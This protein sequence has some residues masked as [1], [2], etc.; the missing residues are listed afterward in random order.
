M[1]SINKQFL[2]IH[3]PKTGGNSIQIALLKYSEDEKVVSVG[4]DG[5]N[6]F[7]IKS[8]R[9]G[10]NKHSCLREYARLMEAGIYESLFKFSTIRNPWDKCVSWYFSPHRGTTTWNRKQF[11]KLVQNSIKPARSFLRTCDGGDLDEE[12]DFL[13]RFE[14]L[15]KDFETLC[16][17]LHLP[18]VELPRRNVSKRQ[19]Y[20]TYYDQ[21][22]RNLVAKKFAE[23]IELGKY[24]F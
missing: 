15:Q 5:D 6:R 16:N 3:L 20:Q 7:N 10:T 17:K 22:V 21:Q 24:T 8:Q 12:V 14:H 9:Y 1:I 2:F 11:V 13:L 4:V 23:E 18:Q 19:P